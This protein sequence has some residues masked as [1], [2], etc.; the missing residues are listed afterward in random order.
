MTVPAPRAPLPTA[1]LAASLSAVL[2][3]AAC[4][5][6]PRPG[7]YGTV[8]A[9]SPA[10]AGRVA[11]ARPAALQPPPAP[12]PAVVSIAPDGLEGRYAG[13]LRLAPNQRRCAPAGLP[14]AMTVAGGRAAFSTGRGTVVEGTIRA[15]GSISFDGPLAVNGSFVAPRFI[16]HAE[17]GSCNYL[18]ELTR[19]GGAPAARAGTAA[20]TAIPVTAVTAER[21]APARAVPPVPAAAAG[22]PARE[23]SVRPP[24]PPP[25]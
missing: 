13:A 1:A 20:A 9:A 4:A 11:P 15:D 10:V 22:G 12:T 24:G 25:G 6:A 21:E 16:G 14:A 5:Q 3:L 2:A 18:V 7:P 17:R 23:G 19:R 8:T